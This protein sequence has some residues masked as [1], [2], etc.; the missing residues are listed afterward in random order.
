[1][2]WMWNLAT[3]LDQ[4]LDKNNVESA[5]INEGNISTRRI[6]PLRIN[7]PKLENGKYF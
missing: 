3:L 4:K 6:I 2:N 5:R 7:N 1:M